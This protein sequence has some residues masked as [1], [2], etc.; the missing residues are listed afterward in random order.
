[1]KDIYFLSSLPRA[2]NTLLG[3]IINDNK[4]VKCTA[5][6]ITPFI[7]D[8]LFK[9]KEHLT[10]KNFPDHK[11]L[12]NLIKNVF[13]KYYEN[14]NVDVII[15]R[16]VWGTPG[17]LKYL[18][19]I[20]KEPKFILL[21]RPVLECISSFVRLQIENGTDENVIKENIYS[22]LDINTGIIGKSLWSIDNIIKTKQNYKIFYYKDLVNNTDSF[23]KD[24]SEYIKVDIKLPNTL[25]Q[26]SVNN[27]KYDDS[28]HKFNLH[29]IKTESI[30]SS[31]YNVMKYIPK[32]IIKRYKESNENYR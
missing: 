6:S 21:I 4:N 25:K 22:L 2:G 3:S 16:S 29:T 13:K 11:S 26:F 15:D 18:K 20:F 27:I 28:V 8:D 10:F 24:L 23:L 1:M 32:E 5:N 31:K 12:D 19:H 9:L 7:L 30:E 17:N 14:W